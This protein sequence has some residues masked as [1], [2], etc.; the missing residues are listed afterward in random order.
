MDFIAI[1]LKVVRAQ[2]AGAA[3][4]FP[5]TGFWLSYSSSLLTSYGSLR[6]EHFLCSSAAPANT[7]P[8]AS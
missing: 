2:T 5:D 4:L 1:G 6:V 8:W 7:P 3:F